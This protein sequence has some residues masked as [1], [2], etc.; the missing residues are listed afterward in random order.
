MH[1]TISEP[2]QVALVYVLADAPGCVCCGSD[3]ALHNS[4]WDTPERAVVSGEPIQSSSRSSAWR[5]L[6][7]RR[8]ARLARLRATGGAAVLRPKDVRAQLSVSASTLRDWTTWFKEY[9]S[10][11]VQVTPEP[12]RVHRRY[13]AADVQKLAQIGQLLHLGHKREE[14]KRQLG[15]PDRSEHSACGQESEQDRRVQAL[16]ASLARAR[17]LIKSLKSECGRAEQ[18]RE[19][20]SAAKAQAQ[21]EL[22]E[23]QRK[24]QVALS[25]NQRLTQANIGLHAQVATWSAS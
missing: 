24:L 6:S 2:C 12:G 16:E 7:A 23:M 10:P 11:A 15:A 22:V 13:T 8:A 1:P 20:E 5:R 21:R 3:L 4:L 25:T 14:V 19:A 9:L 18:L 17:G